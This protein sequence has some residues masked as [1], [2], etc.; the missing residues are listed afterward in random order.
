M[1][2]YKAE[3]DR[4]PNIYCSQHTKGWLVVD[5]Q[6]RPSNPYRWIALCVSEGPAKSIAVALNL[7]R[8]VRDAIANTN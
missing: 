3:Y 1:Q 8:D 4:I 6:L 2:R 7:A 5:T